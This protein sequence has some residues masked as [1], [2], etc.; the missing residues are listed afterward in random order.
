MMALWEGQGRQKL[1][2]SESI[3]KVESQESADGFNV[4]VREREE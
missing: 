1:S 3:L 4:C 2:D